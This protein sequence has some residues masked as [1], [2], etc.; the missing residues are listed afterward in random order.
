MDKLQN[1]LN[2]LSIDNEK[3]WDF[4][5]EYRSGIHKIASYPATMVAAMQNDVIKAVVNNVSD[6]EN[7]LDPFHGSGTTLVE[8][9]LY[10]LSPIGI[11]IN[12]LA[13]IITRVKLEG[14]NRKRV[15]R[16]I[17][18]IEEKFISNKVYEKHGFPN[19]EKWF[20]ED[21]ILDLSK[22]RTYIIEEPVANVRRFFWV[23]LIDTIK[24]HS[25]TRN[26]TFKLHVKN[27]DVINNMENRVFEDFKK[28]VEGFVDLVPFYS[29][30]VAKGKQL[31]NGNCIFELKKIKENSVDFICTSP[32]YGDNPTTVT[33]GQYSILPLLWFSDSDLDK[34]AKQLLGN[35]SSIDT[36]SLGG[37]LSTKAEQ[38]V[39]SLNKILNKI[40]KQ[41]QKKI[42][43]F[44]EDYRKVLVELSRV[45]KDEKYM[46]ITLGNRRVD[47]IK[48]PLDEIT[49]EILRKQGVKKITM[50]ERNIP[51]KRMPRKVSSVNEK[52][53]ESMNSEYLII[54]KKEK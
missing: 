42:I 14:V 25:N 1:A 46:A 12:P 51:Q 27:S 38:E 20:R 23:C 24:K 17:V 6:V 35:F 44:T 10:G 30:E 53:V 52:A 47:N 2:L 32:P 29:R 49:D 9:V 39:E 3:Y 16:S 18:E 4:E 8:G 37:K 34:Y 54:Y 41:K 5:K 45:L 13:S 19:I 33:Y 21:V 22:L 40:N 28:K 48:I 43:A 50:I 7:I 26:T 36:A 15:Y 31:K 11:D